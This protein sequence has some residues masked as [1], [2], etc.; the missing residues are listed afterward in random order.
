MLV[1]CWLYI[2]AGSYHAHASTSQEVSK[3]RERA[4]EDSTWRVT[5]HQISAGEQW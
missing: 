5:Y 1:V 3:K 2:F 4:K